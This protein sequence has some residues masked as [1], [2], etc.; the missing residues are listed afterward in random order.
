MNSKQRIRLANDIKASADRIASAVNRGD[1][2]HKDD[3]I[4]LREDLETLYR[5]T[6]PVLV[7]L[8]KP[9]KSGSALSGSARP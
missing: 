4:L 9:A 3:Y 2:P 6:R 1:L 7:K 5:E 8:N